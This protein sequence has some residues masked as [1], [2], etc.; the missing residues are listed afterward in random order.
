MSDSYEGPSDKRPKIPAWALEPLDSALAPLR[1]DVEA[2]TV[3]ADG[4][5]D[6][7]YGLC[8]EFTA[9]KLA[10]VLAQI[11]SRRVKDL[12]G[13]PGAEGCGHELRIIIKDRP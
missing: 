11:L 9:E 7:C 12:L 6:A 2:E 10:A 1:F 5:S 8:G 3:A 4:T 13:E